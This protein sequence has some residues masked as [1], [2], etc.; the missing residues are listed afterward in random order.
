MASPP[1][2]AALRSESAAAQ[3]AFLFVQALAAE[4]S[5]GQVELP[6]FP[7]IVARVQHVLADD[8]V[9]TDKVVRV[10]GSEPVLTARLLQ[11]ANSAALNISGKPVVDLRAAVTRVG[12]NIVRSSTIA[13]AAQQLA[14]TPMLKGLEKP[15]EALWERTTLVAAL[16]YVVARRLTNVNADAAMLAGLLHSIG[17]LYILTRASRHRAL[18][19]DA[20]SY[21][22]IERDWHLGIATALLE[23]WHMP[24][25][26]VSAVRDCEDLAREPRGAVSL[27]DVL[28]AASLIALHKDQPQMLEARLLSVKPVARMQINAAVCE[29]LLSQSADEIAALREALS[30]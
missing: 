13:F 10:V 14:R 23:N 21:H 2:P 5:S 28:V 22:A 30:I 16:S 27:T 29:A 26:I 9:G 3:D 25:E 12:L 6:G 18:F 7:D 1:I 24:D 11:M 15:L 19:N 4:L 20:A 8:N 17:R